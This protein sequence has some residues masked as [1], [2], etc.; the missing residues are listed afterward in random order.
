MVAA[1]VAQMERRG[2][3]NKDVTQR[4]NNAVKRCLG[5]R[6]DDDGV[7]SEAPP[8]QSWG[9]G[10]VIRGQA[11]KGWVDLVERLDSFLHGSDLELKYIKIVF[12]ISIDLLH[13][14]LNLSHP[15]YWLMVIKTSLL[16]ILLTVLCAPI[17]FLFYSPYECPIQREGLPVL[18]IQ[19]WWAEWA[20]A[21]GSAPNWLVPPGTKR[22]EVSSLWQL[23]EGWILANS[24]RSLFSLPWVRSK[25]T[26]L[27][28]LP[29]VLWPSSPSPS[30]SLCSLSSSLSSSLPIL[31]L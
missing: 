27:F 16:F 23:L 13:K 3:R 14:M 25:L 7:L 17:P 6:G 12:T 15:V 24:T 29:F 4:A 20:C 22:W 31:P 18:C 28:W 2:G 11:A 8:A 21:A 10:W 26:S 9:L 1:L 30:P 5:Y 19:W